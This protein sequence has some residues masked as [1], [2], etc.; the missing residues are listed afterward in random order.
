[1]AGMYRMFSLAL[2]A[3]IHREAMSYHGLTVHQQAVCFQ[4]LVFRRQEV[5]LLITST[6][7]VI[8]QYRFIL[9]APGER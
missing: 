3:T 4:V 7:Y 2:K 5:T 9:A 8:A 1:M 6:E